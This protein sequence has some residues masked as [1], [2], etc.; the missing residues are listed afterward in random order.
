MR[1]SPPVA[2]YRFHRKAIPESSWSLA[3]PGPKRKRPPDR[4]YR[5]SDAVAGAVTGTPRSDELA[6]CKV[7][8]G[9]LV[10]LF[11]ELADE[12]LKQLPQLFVRQLVGMEIDIAEF[13]DN[14]EQDVGLVHLL[15]FGRD[16]EE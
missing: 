10:G 11:V 7:V 16:L 9:R 6:R 4:S 14:E 8:A 2:R 1:I 15:D 5:A 13:R 12:V 3:L